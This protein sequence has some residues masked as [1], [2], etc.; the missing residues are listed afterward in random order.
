MLT[1]T[2]GPREAEEDKAAAAKDTRAKPQLPHDVNLWMRRPGLSS[3][4]SF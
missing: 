2:G 4:V 1:D 3:V